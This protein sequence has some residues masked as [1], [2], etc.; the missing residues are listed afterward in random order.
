MAY[1]AV[2]CDKA[3]ILTNSLIANMFIQSK[4]KVISQEKTIKLYETGQKRFVFV[5]SEILKWIY[6]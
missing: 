6:E 1:S 4:V 3:F 2:N 5:E